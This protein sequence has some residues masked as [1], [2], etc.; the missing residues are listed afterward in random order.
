MKRIETFE[1]L[2]QLAIST[3]FSAGADVFIL[4]NGGARSSKRITYYPES[5]TFDVYNDIDGSY[6]ENLS[7]ED[8]LTLTH[9]GLALDNGA[10]F[11]Y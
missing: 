7:E 5:N 3:N 4:L 10:L 8:L 6:D 9:I 1:E 11:L 2:K